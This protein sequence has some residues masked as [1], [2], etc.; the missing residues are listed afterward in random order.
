MGIT[1]ATKNVINY[2]EIVDITIKDANIAGINERAD[3]ADKKNLEQEIRLNY[4][5]G[6]Q[7]ASSDFTTELFLDE[8]KTNPTYTYSSNPAEIMDDNDWNNNWKETSLNSPA[9]KNGFM[10]PRQTPYMLENIDEYNLDGIGQANKC[11]FSRYD[12]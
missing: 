6:R 2:Q 10:R 3:A 11:G 12:T 5:E 9:F 1:K 7:S 4:L 8:S